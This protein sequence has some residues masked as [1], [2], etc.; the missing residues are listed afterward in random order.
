MRALYTILPALFLSFP[1]Y[2]N[3]IHITADTQVEWHQNEQKMVA[4]GNAQASKQDMHI[5]AE[6][7]SAKYV[8]NAQGKNEVSEVHAEQNVIMTNKDTKAFGNT[9]DYDITEDAAILKGMP[10]KIKTPTEEITAVES[11]T[12]YPSQEKAIALGDVEATDKDNNKLYSDSMTAYFKKDNQNQLQMDRV[13][14][15]GN[16][17]IIT[18]D[19]KVTAS[20]GLYLPNESKVKLFDNVTIYQG[21]NILKGDEAETNLNTGISRLLSQKKNGRVSG[22]FKEKKKSKEKSN[23]KK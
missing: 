18:K 22:V 3:E 7:L 5:R 15:D 16:V 9:L 14:I 8:K 1:A 6:K 17:K 20:K 13:E 2:S 19:A 4:I 10:A 12:Y 23:G 11:I 21:E